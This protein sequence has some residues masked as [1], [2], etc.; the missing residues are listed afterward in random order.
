MFN[1]LSV[2]CSKFPDFVKE[3]TQAREAEAKRFA[4]KMPA[5]KV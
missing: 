5:I 1:A 4:A 3:Q 2:L